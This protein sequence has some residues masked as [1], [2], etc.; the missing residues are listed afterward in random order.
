[1]RYSGRF[2]LA[3]R[4]REGS[5]PPLTIVIDTRW[6]ARRKRSGW[7][8]K[9]ARGQVIKSKRRPVDIEGGVLSSNRDTFFRRFNRS[10][11]PPA[12]A[13]A[14]ASLYSQYTTTYNPSH[15]TS[16]KCQYHAAPS[17]AK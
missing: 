14:R 2:R 8:G 13:E 6:F 10:N 17:K 3:P 11:R 12:Q 1:M 4:L 5:P 16:T 7:R 15:T 9:L